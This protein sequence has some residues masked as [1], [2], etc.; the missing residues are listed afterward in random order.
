MARSIPPGY[1]YLPGT[2]RRVL[3]PTGDIISRRQAEKIDAQARGH[4]D[5]EAQ[6]AT[7]GSGL[8][9]AERGY[10]DSWRR[11]AE[12]QGLETRIRGNADYQNFKRELRDLER[13]RTDLINSMG[14][15]AGRKEYQKQFSDIYLRY[16]LI[17]DA[18]YKKYVALFCQI[19]IWH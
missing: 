17:T 7:A 19:G 6:R 1:T 12:K 14:K 5:K 15:N 16:G 4:P 2:A 3:T 8:S 10:R 11:N 9:N 13:T 18:Q